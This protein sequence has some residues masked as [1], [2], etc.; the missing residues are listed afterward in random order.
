M[1]PQSKQS[2]ELLRS[3]REVL[4]P[5]T[6]HG[7]PIVG[8]HRHAHL[9]RSALWP[10]VPHLTGSA[11]EHRGNVAFHDG[12]AL[13]TGTGQLPLVRGAY[14]MQTGR[15]ERV[16]NRLWR[17]LWGDRLDCRGDTKRQHP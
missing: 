14:A 3:F 15:I 13:A 17:G 1:T 16:Q 8:H 4:L 11:G 10:F 5:D 6:H 7:C 2:A 12:P 9:E